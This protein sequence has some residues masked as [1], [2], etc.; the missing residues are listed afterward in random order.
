MDSASNS[1]VTDMNRRGAKAKIVI[2]DAA[3]RNPFERRFRAAPAGLAPIDAPEGTLTMYSTAPG[4]LLGDSS[5]TSS[6]FTTELVKELRVDSLTAEE[7]FNRTRIAVSRASNGE[8]V[9]WV[10]SSLIEEFYFGTTRP[11]AGRANS[12]TRSAIICATP[13]DQPSPVCC[14]STGSPPLVPTLARI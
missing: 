14:R 9:P 6:L 7:S 13:G 11:S 12:G 10:A 1:L 2:I 3:R 4:K 8:Q 5:A